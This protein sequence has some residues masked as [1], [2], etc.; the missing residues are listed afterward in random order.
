MMTKTSPIATNLRMQANGVT[1]PLASSSV[2]STTDV[3]LTTAATNMAD[4]PPVRFDGT[5][6]RV[7][8][9]AGRV[10]RPAVDRDLRGRTA[11]QPDHHRRRT[12]QCGLPAADR[13]PVRGRQSAQTPRCCRASPPTKH[14]SFFN[15]TSHSRSNRLL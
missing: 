3:P 5:A 11:D 6:Y 14:S 1:I 2:T 12:P 4:L 15:W 13:D 8:A 7:E 9:G 10:G